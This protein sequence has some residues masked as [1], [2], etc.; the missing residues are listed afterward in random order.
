M[1]NRY[2]L[3]NGIQVV[4][5][6]MPYL[7]TAAFGLWVKTGSAYENTYN[8]GIAHIIEHMM[9]KGT[10]THN[11][12]ELADMMTRIGGNLNAFTAKECTGYYVKTLDEHL[13]FAVEIISDMIKNS[14]FSPEDLSKEKRVILEEIDMYNDSPEDLVHELLQKKIWQGH[15]LGYLISGTKKN[16][17]S[18]KRNDIYNFYKKN[19]TSE[20]MVISIAGNCDESRMIEKLEKEFGDIEKSCASQM[21]PAP[22]YNAVNVKK[23]KDIEQLHINLAFPGVG[24]NSGERYACSIANSVLGGSLNSRLF[25]H[26]REELG[27]TYTIYSYESQYQDTGLFHIYAALNHS[28]ATYVVSEIL[29]CVRDFVKKGITSEELSSTKEQLITEYMLGMENTNFRMENNA[30]YLLLQ[31]K[32]VTFDEIIDK[33]KNVRKEEVNLFLEKYLSVGSESLCV[34][35]N[36]NEVDFK[37]IQEAKNEQL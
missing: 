23:H 32:C 17:K 27:L 35:G 5:E 34:V 20:N 25:Q 8:N 9:F 28:Q 12:R 3:S 14:L 2:T 26:I 37:R 22:K 15:P 4:I 29:K 31:G 30:K 21:L 1:I 6:N 11:A 10:N 19:Y 16:V 36:L 7:R 33:I 13:Y 24:Y 18:L